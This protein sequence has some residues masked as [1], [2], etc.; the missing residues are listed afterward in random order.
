[1]VWVVSHGCLIERVCGAVTLDA[2]GKP[3]RKLGYL[4]HLVLVPRLAAV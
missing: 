3:V 2:D 4:S 1:V